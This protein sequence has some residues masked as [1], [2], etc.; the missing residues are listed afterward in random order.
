MMTI[1]GFDESTVKS[2]YKRDSYTLP[3]PRILRP[4]YNKATGEM[5]D[6]GDSNIP[7]MRE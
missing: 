4:K 5:V 1:P 2:A 6:P 3:K 7:F